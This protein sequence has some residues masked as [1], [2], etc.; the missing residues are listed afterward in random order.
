MLILAALPFATYGWGV[1]KTKYEVR[2][3]ERVAC[4]LRIAD[5]EKRINA[6]AD[7]K[8]KAALDAAEATSPTPEVLEEIAALCAKDAACRDR[9]Q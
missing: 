6:D 5:I 1:V 2:A 9:N 3:Q 4:T 7:A 8:I